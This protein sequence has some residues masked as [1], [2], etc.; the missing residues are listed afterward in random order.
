MNIMKK[1]K[2]TY[3]KKDR[4]PRGPID[5]REVKVRISIF[6]DGDVLHAYK[7]AAQKTTHGKYQTLMNEKLRS[8]IFGNNVLDENIR[9]AIRE[10]VRR[11]KVA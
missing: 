3:G 10:E 4:L 2:I 1:N 11:Q 5:Y 6:I 9:K 7:E 8:A